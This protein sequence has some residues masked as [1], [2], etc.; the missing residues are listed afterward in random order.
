MTAIEV[1]Y[2]NQVKKIS[3]VRVIYFQG[4]HCNR[5]KNHREGELF[6]IT[7]KTCIFL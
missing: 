3:V 2:E 4:K 1:R 7:R 6:N 5:G